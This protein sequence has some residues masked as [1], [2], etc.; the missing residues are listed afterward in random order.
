[1]PS[2]SSTALPSSATYEHHNKRHSSSSYQKSRLF[3]DTFSSSASNGC[4]TI[5][6]SRHELDEPSRFERSSKRGSVMRPW[7]NAEQESLY[8]AVERFKLFG[9]WHEIKARM[10]LDRSLTEIENE[11]MRLYAEIPGSDE[12][13]MDYDDPYQG[14]EQ[15]SALPTLPLT[16][17]SSSALSACSSQGSI[18]AL[19]D[20]AR[21]STSCLIPG[22]QI[23]D[24]DG[25]D[26]LDDEEDE[27]QRHPQR[28]QHIS[29]DT[30][31]QRMVRV[32]TQEQ[33]ENLR[34]L[35]EVHFPGAYRINWVWVA[36][37]MGNIF[38]RKQ[39]K[40]KWEII[41]RR[42]GT[43]KEI[44]QLKRGYQ[45]FRPSWQQIQEKYMPE[46]SRGGIST[47]WN[48]LETRG[49]EQQQQQ[50]SAQK[51]GQRAVRGL[52]HGRYHSTSSLKI[53]QRAS[54]LKESLPALR[55]M[56]D[57]YDVH[58]QW[59]K[60]LTS[61]SAAMDLSLLAFPGRST[62]KEVQ[63]RPFVCLMKEPKRTFLSA[64]RH[65]RYRS[66]IPMVH[67]SETLSDCSHPT[68]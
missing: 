8:I 57:Q 9:Q 26:E 10:N 32:W 18:T 24:A 56:G 22:Q 51:T 50:Q 12:E 64:T 11:Y 44:N 67:P 1:M 65:V 55:T 39:C 25:D 6:S 2:S 17:V 15:C 29:T 3:M 59:R 43:E 60:I 58:A 68:T 63:L 53:F 7:T 19:C 33:S 16:V 46:W 38:T 37:Q 34:N 61:E 36:A 35:I 48:L 45:E 52:H 42:M 62:V 5:H 27:P 20:R 47:M 23:V 30:R 28:Y 40:N 13:S 14:T 4:H 31:P 54:T 41:R 21:D 66:D 49:A